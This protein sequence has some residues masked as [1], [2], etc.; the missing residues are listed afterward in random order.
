MLQKWRKVHKNKEKK[1]KLGVL[2]SMLKKYINTALNHVKDFNVNKWINAC[3]ITEMD[4]R[5]GDRRQ[6]VR[7]VDARKGETKRY[8]SRFASQNRV[9]LIQMSETMRSGTSFLD[10]CNC[11]VNLHTGAP[12]PLHS[13]TPKAVRDR[14]WSFCRT[15]NGGILDST[16]PIFWPA[17]CWV[18]IIAL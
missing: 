1:K 16:W 15:R 13:R 10:R 6:N 18:R 9:S 3:P 5:P 17:G 8:Q 4:V 7:S 14:I 11:I 2:R 12:M